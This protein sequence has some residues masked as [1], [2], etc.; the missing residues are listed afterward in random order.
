MAAGKRG[1]PSRYREDASIVVRRL[2]AIFDA[3]AEEIAAYL[4]VS[5]STLSAWARRHPD[6]NDALR[7]VPSIGA[8]GVHRR[9]DKVIIARRL[10]DALRE[11]LS[12]STAVAAPASPSY[13]PTA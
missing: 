5:T 2:R 13:A 7:G 3:D 4:G 9:G 8:V 6:L 1:R 12:A 11:A 10:F